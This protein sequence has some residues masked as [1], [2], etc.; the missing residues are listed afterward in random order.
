M[1]F[2]IQTI[3]D[4]VLEG[5]SLANRSY[6]GSFDHLAKILRNHLALGNSAI[7][8]DFARNLANFGRSKSNFEVSLFYNFLADV[9]DKK[10]KT[11]LDLEK[12]SV[13]RNMNIKGRI[14]P[15]KKLPTYTQFKS[16][17]RLLLNRGRNTLRPA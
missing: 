5:T 14:Q 12:R 4:L 16:A 6:K 10:F 8:I 1:K 7:S 13:L 2:D 15:I 3:L 9:A 17:F 11:I